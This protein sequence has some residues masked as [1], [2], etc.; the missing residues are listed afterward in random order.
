MT[1]ASG[2]LGRACLRLLRELP[3]PPALTL[4]LRPPARARLEQEGLLRSEWQALEGDLAQPRLGLV[5]DAYQRLAAGL[6]GVFHCAGNVRFDLRLEQARRV[7]LEGTRRLLELA[8][9]AAGG[10]ARPRFDHVSTAYVVGR[11]E[12]RFDEQDGPGAAGFCN[13]YEQTKWEAEQ[14]V[15]GAGGALAVTVYRPSILLPSTADSDQPGSLAPVWCA[16]MLRRGRLLCIPGRRSARLDLIGVDT[17]ARALAHYLTRDSAPGG[18]IHLTAG[19]DHAATF[20]ELVELAAAQLGVRPPPWIEPRLFR[21]WIRPLLWLL[22]HGQRRS[23][24]LSGENLL[25][26]LEQSRC[27]EPRRAAADFPWWQGEA[28]RAREQVRALLQ[29]LLASGRI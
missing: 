3:E 29:D 6:R 11:R 27:F 7:N 28:A 8:L 22:L 24:W 17:A 5:E 12:G 19:C 2:F 15:R 9:A 10:G 14:L 25:P 4:L 16:R 26:Y 20:G 13:S 23:V 1:G 18:T 21:R